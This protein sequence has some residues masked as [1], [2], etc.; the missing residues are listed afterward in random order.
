MTPSSGVLFLDKAEGISSHKSLS[1]VK[2]H[3]NTRKVGHAGTLD[4]F[5]SGMLIVLVKQATRLQDYFM[6]HDKRYT[7]TIQLGYQSDTL[8]REGKLEPSKKEVKAFSDELLKTLAEKFTGAQD[9]VPPAFSAIHI[10]GKRAYQ[11]ARLGMEV[12]IPSRNIVVKDLQLMKKNDRQIDFAVTC[13]A[14]TYVRSLARDIAFELETEGYLE[15]LRRTEVGK[16]KMDLCQPPDQAED[17]A[18]HSVEDLLPI[19]ANIELNDKQQQKLLNGDIQ[20]LKAQFLTDGF[21][22]LTN[23]KKQK[24]A[25]VRKENSREKILLNYLL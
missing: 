13:S 12:N 4:P 9:Q 14:G 6:G 1:A 10:N 21:Y 8:D 7:G 25:L 18:C 19:R 15:S 22:S 5:A 11:L 3:F 16:W 17:W 2:K 24:L 23:P 20:S